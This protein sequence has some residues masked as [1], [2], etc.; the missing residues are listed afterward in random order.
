MYICKD[1]VNGGCPEALQTYMRCIYIYVCTYINKHICKQ[2][3]LSSF[4]MDSIA[5]MHAGY[6]GYTGINVLTMTGIR[7]VSGLLGKVCGWKY[8]YDDMKI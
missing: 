1:G 2:V 3:I 6:S 7:C 5:C 8:R 4:Q